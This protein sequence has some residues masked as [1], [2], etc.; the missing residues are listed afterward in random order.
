M[1]KP[2]SWFR[3][4]QN[5]TNK[6]VEVK[7][8][9]SN[10]VNSYNNGNVHSKMSADLLSA[11]SM[12]APLRGSK[13][14]AIVPWRRNDNSKEKQQADMKSPSLNLVSV[15]V[16]P[17]VV[18]KAEANK[19]YEQTMFKKESEATKNFE[20]PSKQDN[21]AQSELHSAEYAKAANECEYD[22]CNIIV[23]NNIKN[24][25]KNIEKED[26]EEAIT[27][28]RERSFSPKS[29]TKKEAEDELD[30]TIRQLEVHAESLCDNTKHDP[31]PIEYVTSKEMSNSAKEGVQEP[32]ARKFK[33][34]V[35][36]DI[37][38][39]KEECQEIPT[40]KCAYIVKS[41]P[42][43]IPGEES[44]SEEDSL[45]YEDDFSVGIDLPAA[46]DNTSGKTYN[47]WFMG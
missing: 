3:E 11:Q 38:K 28:S 24:V 8:E 33:N 20:E 34:P 21:Q 35:T 44:D 18:Q 15:T 1:L 6:Q 19:K 39:T 22:G 4:G 40:H 10:E 12:E 31:S 17:S 47:S 27:L 43:N 36:Q 26:K 16:T 13:E 2:N 45:D 41:I 32:N 29:K 42:K 14:E 37:N 9:L 25:N 23:T 46:M 30:E 7:S 5:N